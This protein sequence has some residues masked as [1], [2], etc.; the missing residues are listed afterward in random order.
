VIVKR[1]DAG[2]NRA[3]GVPEVDVVEKQND[4]VRIGSRRRPHEC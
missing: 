1:D 3:V 4:S 2:C